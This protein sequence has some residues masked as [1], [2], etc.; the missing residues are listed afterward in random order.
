MVTSMLTYKAHDFK[1][2][3][4][5]SWEKV[6]RFGGHCQKGLKL[7]NLFSEVGAAPKPLQSKLAIYKAE[8]QSSFQFKGKGTTKSCDWVSFIT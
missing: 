3:L 6:A 1:M 4:D 5:K 7:L 8:Y 2:F